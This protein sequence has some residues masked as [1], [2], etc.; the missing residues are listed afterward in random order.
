MKKTM[1]AMLVPVCLLIIITGTQAQTYFRGLQTIV[2]PS[3]V[4]IDNYTGIVLGKRAGNEPGLNQF[5]RSNPYSYLQVVSDNG[6]KDYHI[7]FQ[8]NFSGK[9]LFLAYSNNLSPVFNNAGKSMNVFLNCIRQVNDFV[10][11]VQNAETAIN[12]IIERLNYCSN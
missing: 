12:C 2:Q 1:K 10:S 6:G 5:D 4:I 11:P 8:T 3:Q 9:I 7:L